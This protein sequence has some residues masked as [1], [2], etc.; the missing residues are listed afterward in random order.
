M[1]IEIERKFLVNRQK[2]QPVD[3]GMVYRQGYIQTKNGNTVRVR[4]AGKQGFLTLK[5][6]VRNLTRSEFE[7]PI[8]LIDAEE[9]LTLLC[10]RP[11]IEK[12]RYKITFDNFL[13]EVDRF[14]GDN[15]GLMI[16]EIELTSEFE[17]FNLPPWVDVEVTHDHRYFNSYLAQ[18][19]YKCWE[20]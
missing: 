9:M 8:P 2:W 6:K 18:H 7:Y 3:K 16:A 17:I 11:L 13:W 12:I 1:A 20:Y 19:P 10:D 15:E 4:V 5:S 14:L